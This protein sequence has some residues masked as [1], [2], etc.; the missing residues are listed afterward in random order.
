M[1]EMGDGGMSNTRKLIDGL[2]N[3]DDKIAY[4]YLKV[5]EK[6]SV[7]SSEVY[8][9]FD[10]FAEMLE[11]EN[12]YIRTRGFLLIAANTKWDVDNKIDEII[13]KLLECISDEKPITAR[14]CIKVLPAIIKYKP[15]LKDCVVKALENP[16]LFRYKESMRSLI[17]RD[18]KNTLNEID[19]L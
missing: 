10:N 19:D 2:M 15:G 13:D 18:I 9:F 4:E 5:L 1:N 8:S 11:S 7:C 12:S 16:D 3:H 14:Q 6:K 17:V